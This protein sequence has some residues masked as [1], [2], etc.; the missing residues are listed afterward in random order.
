MPRYLSPQWFEEVNAATRP[1]G[2]AADTTGAARLTLQQVV[3]GAPEGEVRYWVRVRDGSVEAGLG[4]AA[5]ADATVSQSYDTAVAVVTGQLSVQAALMAGRIRLSG[6][7]SALV[8]QHEALEGI[9]AA[10]ADV[11]RRTTYE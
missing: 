4:E 2:Q 5:E 11:R 10:F 1:E 6:R 7:I 9:D 8:D 3:T